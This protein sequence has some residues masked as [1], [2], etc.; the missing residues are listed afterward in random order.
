MRSYGDTNS[1]SSSFGYLLTELPVQK[2]LAF[3]GSDDISLITDLNPAISDYGRGISLLYRFQKI[4]VL[5]F[6]FHFQN[7]KKRVW[8]LEILLHIMEIK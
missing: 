6:N 2:Y 5:T 1:F 3:S 7:Q 4:I 8:L